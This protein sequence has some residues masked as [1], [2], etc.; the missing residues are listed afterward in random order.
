MLLLIVINKLILYQSNETD[1]NTDINQSISNQTNNTKNNVIGYYFE[2][3]VNH[4]QEKD[5]GWELTQAIVSNTI[6]MAFVVI[7]A[8]IAYACKKY[9]LIFINEKQQQEKQQQQQQNNDQIEDPSFDI[10][11]ERDIDK[12]T[13]DIKEDKDIIMIDKKN[14]D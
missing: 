10:V 13:T 7:G 4:I 9:I 1:N 5:L 8:I 6:A 2:M 3:N 14:R 12:V 11:Y